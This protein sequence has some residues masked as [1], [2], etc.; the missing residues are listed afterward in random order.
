MVNRFYHVNPVILS[1]KTLVTV[2]A[3]GFVGGGVA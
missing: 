2:L 3:D 1:K